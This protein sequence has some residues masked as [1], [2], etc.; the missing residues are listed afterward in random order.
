MSLWKQAVALALVVVPLS[1]AMAAPERQNIHLLSE[2]EAPHGQYSRDIGVIADPE[3]GCQY[4]MSHY[5]GTI[6]PRL[7]SD[8]KP[9]CSPPAPKAVQ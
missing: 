1:V 6:T 5:H 8:G 3:T 2:I 9:M 7:G 4:L